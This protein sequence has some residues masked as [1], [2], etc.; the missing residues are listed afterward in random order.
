[1]T[2]V[3]YAVA[4]FCAVLAVFCA[5]FVVVFFT[6]RRPLRCPVCGRD[7]TNAGAHGHTVDEYDA[8]LDRVNQERGQR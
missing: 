1:M 6:T 4:T 2:P 8:W 3:V 5:V 7:I